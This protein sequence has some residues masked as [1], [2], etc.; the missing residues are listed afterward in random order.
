MAEE[1]TVLFF[2]YAPTSDAVVEKIRCHLGYDLITDPDG[3]AEVGVYWDAD[4]WRDQ[5][6][7]WMRSAEALRILNRRCRHFS[8]TRVDQVFERVFGRSLRVDPR[9]YV[10]AFVA[11]SDENAMHDGVV[12]EQ[13]VDHP[14]RD[15]VY[16]RLVDNHVDG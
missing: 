2:P 7:A 6:P 9:A 5:P 13:P 14:T 16:Q 3:K 12:L 1:R 15:R 8:K 10:G 4:T 11:K